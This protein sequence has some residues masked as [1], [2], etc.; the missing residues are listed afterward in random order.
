MRK[1]HQSVNWFTER[2]SAGRDEE[3][4]GEEREL[5]IVC[6]TAVTDNIR[7]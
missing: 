7:S 1:F 3:G 4:V 2:Q 6:M 5:E